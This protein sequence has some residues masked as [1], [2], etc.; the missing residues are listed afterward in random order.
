MDK[1]PKVVKYINI[2]YSI[3]DLDI[4]LVSWVPTPLLWQALKQWDCHHRGA[5]LND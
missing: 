3:L 5:S 2:S 4:G 1:F